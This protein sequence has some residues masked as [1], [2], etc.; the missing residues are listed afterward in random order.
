MENNLKTKFLPG[1]RA[2]KILA[3]VWTLILTAVLAS[4][5]VVIV[6]F[7]ARAQSAQTTQAFRAGRFA[8]ETAEVSVKMLQPYGN[9]T[10]KMLFKVDTVTGDVWAL[11]VST[12][13]HVNPEIQSAN[14]V[15]VQLSTPSQINMFQQF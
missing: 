14:W 13:S 9:N 5:L 10:Q 3:L 1:S 12:R 15:K 6:F 8:L 2:F 11:Q 4:V 7:P